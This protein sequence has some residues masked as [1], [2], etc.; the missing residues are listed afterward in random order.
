[1]SRENFQSTPVIT[2]DPK[3]MDKQDENLKKLLELNLDT[4]D[5]KKEKKTKRLSWII[6]G[7]ITD[8]EN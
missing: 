1:M 6:Q 3:E 8:G 5:V 2:S 7:N 4:N